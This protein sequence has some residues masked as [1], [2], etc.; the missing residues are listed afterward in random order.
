MFP[1]T[2]HCQIDQR[3][4]HVGDDPVETQSP[5]IRIQRELPPLSVVNHPNFDN[6]AV[7]CT[8]VY[9]QDAELAVKASNHFGHALRLLLT[10]VSK[11]WRR[12]VQR[13]AR[14][15][16]RS[17]MRCRAHKQRLGTGDTSWY[18]SRGKQR[19]TQNDERVFR[20]YW[21]ASLRNPLHM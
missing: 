11:T 5:S 17:Q 8:Y 4:C 6:Q 2:E 7:L 13:L 16:G 12:D 3:C 1:V 10:F 19:S 15:P 20:T 9:H 18:E 14:R 21:G